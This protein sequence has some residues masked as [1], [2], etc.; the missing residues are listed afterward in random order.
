MDTDALGRQARYSSNGGVSTVADFSLVDFE[1]NG[2]SIRDSLAADDKLSRLS[3]KHAN[4]GLGAVESGSAIAKAAAINSVYSETGVRAIVGE[5]RTDDQ[6]HADL[7]AGDGLNGDGDGVLDTDER[8]FGSLGSVKGVTLTANTYLE[9]NGEKISGFSFLDNDADGELTRQIN[10]LYEQTGVRAEINSNSELVLIAKDGRDISIAYHGDD[11]VA[12]TFDA[13]FD[14]RLAANPT[15]VESLELMIGLRSGLDG[16]I[17]YGGQL[18]LQSNETFEMTTDFSFMANSALGGIIDQNGTPTDP[19]GGKP[20]VMGTNREATVGTIDLSTSSGALR[21]LDVLDLALEQ[22]SSERSQLGAMQNR[23]ESTINNLTQ[24]AEN[25]SAASGRIKDADFAAETA[26]LASN[27]IKQQ[28]A[29]SMLAQ[30]S[31]SGQI[32]L[33]LLQ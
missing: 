4:F 17:S 12:G 3:S 13:E 25:L 7:F 29:V 24:T 15:V 18:T 26:Q 8:A 6:F 2:V 30:V 1:I 10:A 32:V 22:I 21:A 5:T 28:A 23:T 16:A 14:T 31:Q 20:F 33:S 27:Q 9:I 19:P 11:A